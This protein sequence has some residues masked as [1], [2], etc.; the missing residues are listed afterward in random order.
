MPIYMHL[1]GVK[2]SVTSGADKQVV[3]PSTHDT[4][5][6]GAGKVSYSD[7]A[8]TPGA[9][10][11]S[12]VVLETAASSG[13]GKT[14][15]AALLGRATYAEQSGPDI[16]EPDL[17]SDGG[18]QA[19]LDHGVAVLAWARVDGVGLSEP[20]SGFDSVVDGT[21]ADTSVSGG[22]PGSFYIDAGGV[23]DGVS[24]I[25]AGDTSQ[26]VAPDGST[27]ESALLPWDYIL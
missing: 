19:A 7:M 20:L 18:E 2:G 26:L 9:E 11:D 12:A 21:L 24:S 8:F 17:A 23:N 3:L 22:V 13:T 6:G 25:L 14:L 10:A 16:W 1:E 5:D 15:S 4:G 27:P